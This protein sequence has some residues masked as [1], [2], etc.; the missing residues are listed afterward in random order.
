LLVLILTRVDYKKV[1]PRSLWISMGMIGLAGIALFLIFMFD[2]S[3]AFVVFHEIFFDNDLW[4][5]DPATSYMIRMLP[6]GLFYDMIMR[7]LLIFGIGL[8]VLL[9]ASIFFHKL[10]WN[11][12]QQ[13]I[14]TSTDKTT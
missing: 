3:H 8:V 2:F 4:L 1:I 6:E 10:T 9:A 5:F 11:K 13:A 14:I 7:V 12:N